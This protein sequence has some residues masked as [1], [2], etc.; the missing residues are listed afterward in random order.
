MII[1]IDAQFECDE[2]G[3]KF[4]VRLDPGYAPDGDNWTVFGIAEE[5]IR[6][7]HTYMDEMDD[8]YPGIAS[9]DGQRHLC[10]G[11]T[12]EQDKEEPIV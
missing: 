4:V 8:P 12:R 1:S 2:C 5:A 11:C 3:N 6:G 10:A 9:V 7:G